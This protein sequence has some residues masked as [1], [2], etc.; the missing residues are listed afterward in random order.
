MRSSIG[1]NINAIRIHAYVHHRYYA[2]LA[3]CNI[4]FILT[5]GK[6]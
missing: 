4:Y 6:P 2:K 3:L 1:N 5:Y